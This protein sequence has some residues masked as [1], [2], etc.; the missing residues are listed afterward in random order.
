MGARYQRS[1]PPAFLA[2][3]RYRRRFL[4]S[5]GGRSGPD[6]CDARARLGDSAS[7]VGAALP[8]L[9]SAFGAEDGYAFVPEAAGEMRHLAGWPASSARQVRQSRPVLLVLDDCQWADELTYR[10]IRRWQ[11]QR[12][13][14]AAG[15]HV[16]FVV[17]FRSEEVGEDHLLRRVDPDLHLRLS[18]FAAPGSQA[19][20]RIDGRSAAGRRRAGHYPA[21]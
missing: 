11:S 2:T 21:G 12:A 9:A 15:S 1:C 13:D 18:P 20:G 6:A 16:M 7:S 8:G 10:L 14:E 4:V 5:R 17:A 3:E 19:I